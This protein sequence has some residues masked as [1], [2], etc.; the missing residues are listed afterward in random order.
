MKKSHQRRNLNRGKQIERSVR[1]TYLALQ[2][3]ED[4]TQRVDV[5]IK[6]LS[7]FKSL[8]EKWLKYNGGLVDAPRVTQLEEK[9]AKTLWMEFA[10]F[11]ERILARH[12]MQ[13]LIDLIDIKKYMVNE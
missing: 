2:K 3:I 12:R 4:D 11:S 10:L 9:S 7:P 5:L 1:N 13:F 6:T 8:F